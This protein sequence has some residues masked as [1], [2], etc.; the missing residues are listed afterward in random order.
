MSGEREECF[1]ELRLHYDRNTTQ[2]AS[3]FPSSSRKPSVA[4]QRKG[5][6]V[7]HTQAHV[8]TN[9]LRQTDTSKGQYGVQWRA[10][11]CKVHLLCGSKPLLL[12]PYLSLPGR[13]RLNF[14]KSSISYERLEFCMMSIDHSIHFVTC[15]VGQTKH[16][17]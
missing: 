2:T 16:D 7:E 14:A 8:G 10:G 17:F 13:N 5:T 11:N 3:V 6:P 15:S 1:N 4:V 9:H 12:R